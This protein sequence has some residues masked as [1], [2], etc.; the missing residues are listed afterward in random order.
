LTKSTAT[1]QTIAALSPTEPTVLEW[2]F[3]LPSTAATH[4]CLLAVM[5]CPQDPIPAGNKIFN[6]D[7][8]V[9]NEKRVALKNLHVVNIPPATT[10][11]TTLDFF[12]LS[13]LTSGIKIVGTSAS[14]GT[15]GFLLP[16]AAQPATTTAG[17]TSKKGAAVAAEPGGLLRRKLT[18]QMIKS[19]KERLP[20][21]AG[22]LDLTRLYT[23]DKGAKGGGI[24]G[25][26]IPKAGLRAAVVLTAPTK[27]NT[28]DTF[29]VVQ[30]EDGK[31]VGGSTYV[32]VASK[33]E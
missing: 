20:D 3:P 21:I 8:L 10:L 18:D 5:D 29:S 26:K 11:W 14:G 22:K 7:N 1:F 30:E 27:A 32:I 24:S 28:Y 15:V 31:V 16:K 17:K 12:S 13:G 25:V 19:L 6:V 2:D 33:L 9:R 4:S 23:L